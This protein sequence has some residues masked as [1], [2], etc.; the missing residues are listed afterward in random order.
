[1][2]FGTF[3]HLDKSIFPPLFLNGFDLYFY[4]IDTM[5]RFTDCDI[6]RPYMD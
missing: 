1:M 5:I 3:L 2:I 4:P 6:S